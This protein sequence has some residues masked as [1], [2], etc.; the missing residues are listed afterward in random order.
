MAFSNGLS[1]AFSNKNSLVSG[2][3]Q[4]IV[5]RP[6]DCC[7]NR[8]MDV[9]WYFPMEF[10]FCDFWYLNLSLDYLIY[11]DPERCKCLFP[12]L[13]TC[14]C[15]TNMFLP[16]SGTRKCVIIFCPESC[17]E[18]RPSSLT[19]PCAPRLARG[20]RMGGFLVITILW[21]DKQAVRQVAPPER[22]DASR[23]HPQPLRQ[24]RRG[25]CFSSTSIFI[26]S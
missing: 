22:C 1:V 21:N 20:W 14:M 19:P 8:Q 15:F 23:L 5:T 26:E 24:L 12:L 9:Q 7:W 18:A 3:F 16:G 17:S 6:V 4:R 2:I 10:H 13:N 25:P 11:T